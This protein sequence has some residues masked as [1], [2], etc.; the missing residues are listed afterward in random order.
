MEWYT[1]FLVVGAGIVAGFINTL[2]SSGS[3]I[4]LWA[5]NLLSLPLE[6]ANGTN[7]VAILLQTFTA[8][9]LF[10][11]QGK[12]EWNRAVW[13]IV[14]AV[15]GSI[16][17]ASLAVSLDRE[18]LKRVIGVVMLMVLFLLFIKPKRWLEGA[19]STDKRPS[20]FQLIIFF[21]IGAYGGFIQIGVGVFLLTGLVLGAKLDLI[22]ANAIKVA[23]IAAFT[24]PA[25]AIF[26]WNGQVR[27]G[28]GLLLACGN[29]LG[30]WIATKEAAKRGTVFVRWL[31]ILAVSLA[32]IRYLGIFSL[33]SKL[34]S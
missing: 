5:L 25:L 17:G 13:L 34:W 3:A 29:M 22:R 6:I 14:P 32:A 9:R 30:A 8:T 21:F 4:S 23:I 24:I 2:A 11:K 10:H 33:I 7:R 16:L 19:E 1:Y 15:A 18:I 28:I 31:L 20:V 12:I 26:V 27:W